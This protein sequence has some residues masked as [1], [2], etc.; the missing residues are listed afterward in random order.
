MKK[1]IYL[2]F[3]LISFSTYSQDIRSTLAIYNDVVATTKDGFNIGFEFA[4]QRQYSFNKISLFSFPNLNGISYTE[5]TG[6]HGINFHD[7]FEE[8]RVFANIKAGYVWRGSD[9]VQYPIIGFETGYEHYFKSGF[10][11]GG[12]IGYDYRTDMQIADKNLPNTWT[13]LGHLKIGFV[14]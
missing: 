1:T 9:N 10:F 11:I 8:N 6:A 3:I 14:L 12:Y 5:L 2:A 4:Y 7:R 13:K